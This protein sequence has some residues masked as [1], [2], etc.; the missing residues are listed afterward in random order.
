MY[1]SSQYTI[2]TLGLI[3]ALGSALTAPAWTL[4]QNSAVVPF[5]TTAMDRARPASRGRWQADNA[6]SPHTSTASG[7]RRHPM[8]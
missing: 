8:R 2:A 3:S 6:S 4:F 7:A 5:G 1:F